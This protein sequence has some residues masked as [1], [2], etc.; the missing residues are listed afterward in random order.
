MAGNLLS[1]LKNISGYKSIVILTGSVAA[2]ENIPI[3]QYVKSELMRLKATI[4]LLP[5]QPHN[6]VL[7]STT[8]RLFAAIMLPWEKY[9]LKNG[10]KKVRN[11]QTNQSDIL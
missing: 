3:L 10:L 8:S 6:M 11:H 4:I 5:S 9:A 1:P 2:W 7:T